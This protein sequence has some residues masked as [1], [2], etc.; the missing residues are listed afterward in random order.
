MSFLLDTNICSTHMRRP[1][2]M[3]HRFVQHGGNLAISTINLGELYAWAYKQ[4]DPSRILAKIGDF[5]EDVSVL[6]FDSQCAEQFGSLR[7]VLIRQGTVVSPLDVMIASVAL[8]HDLTVV[9]HNTKHFE[10]VPGLR[11]VDWLAS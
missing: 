11:V 6:S 7:G 4:A 10:V 8:V 5:L 1:G 2:G 9:S 3:F